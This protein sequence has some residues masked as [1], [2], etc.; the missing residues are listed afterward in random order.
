MSVE[1]HYC[2]AYA[3]K[4]EE[5]TVAIFALSFDSLDLDSDDKE[6]LQS[7]FSPTASPAVDYDYQETFFPN[8]DTLQWILPTSLYRKSEEANILVIS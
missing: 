3:V 7:G 8:L 6:E 4:F 2:Q 5:E 1:N